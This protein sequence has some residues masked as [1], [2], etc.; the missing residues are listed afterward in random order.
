LFFP[1]GAQVFPPALLARVCNFC[2][3]CLP[4]VYT[5]TSFEDQNF[6]SRCAS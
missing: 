2:V 3:G 4:D 1:A 6:V 5:T